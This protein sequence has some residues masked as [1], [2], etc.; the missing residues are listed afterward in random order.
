M[1]GRAYGQEGKCSVCLRQHV[2]LDDHP[3]RHGWAVQ[4]ITPGQGLLGTWHTGA[5]QGVRFP[6]LGLSVEGTKWALKDAK[7]H[8][9]MVRAHRKML[10]KGDYALTDESTGQSYV[11]G[12]AAY[13]R[14]LGAAQKEADAAIATLDAMITQYQSIITG[15]KPAAAL[16]RDY[17][18]GAVLHKPT[19][20][21]KFEGHRAPLCKSWWGYEPYRGNAV[22]AKRDQD[23]TCPK[24]R[25]TMDEQAGVFAPKQVAAPKGSTVLGK[26]THGWP[27]FGPSAEFV[28]RVKPLMGCY[29]QDEAVRKAVKAHMQQQ[30][31]D[32]YKSDH[33]EA[34]AMHKALAEK[35]RAQYEVASYSQGK[36]DL[37][38]RSVI[39]GAIAHAHRAA[40]GAY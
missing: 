20:E 8:L 13:K 25:K 17:T 33:A 38:T 32:G 16:A 15:W 19:T 23:V 27:V 21:G 12:E 11:R 10:A 1:P 26:T 36:D 34:E 22:Y 24:C 9:K 35:L 29:G 39:H 28:A 6:H 5:C 18:R 30:K 3:I 31:F 14:A 40:S 37:W 7:A 4:N 2:L